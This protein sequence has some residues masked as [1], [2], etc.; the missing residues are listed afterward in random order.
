M[1]R[2]MRG[3]KYFEKDFRATKN[4]I[5]FYVPQV[6]RGMTRM[7]DVDRD[8]TSLKKYIKELFVNLFRLIGCGIHLLLEQQSR[9]AKIANAIEH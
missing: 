8:S 4:I 7:Y 5:F 3:C 6:T 2:V 1:S 9:W